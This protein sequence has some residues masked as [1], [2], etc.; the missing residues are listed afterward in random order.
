MGALVAVGQVRLQHLVPRRPTRHTIQA[1]VRPGPG[2]IRTYDASE[3]W[4]AA[5]AQS[6]EER[7]AFLANV[8]VRLEQAQQHAKHYYDRK[9]MEV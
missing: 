6:I 4:V 9:H 8:R 3:V 7:D 5:V 1:G 2:S